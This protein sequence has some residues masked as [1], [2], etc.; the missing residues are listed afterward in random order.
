M[1]EAGANRTR[2]ETGHDRKD[3]KRIEKR[4]QVDGLLFVSFD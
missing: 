2:A 4:K 1:V 3:K